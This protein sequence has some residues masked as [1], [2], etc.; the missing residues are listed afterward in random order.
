MTRAHVEGLIPPVRVATG[1]RARIRSCRRILLRMRVVARAALSTVGILCLAEIGEN[2]PHLVAAET[3]WRA[4]YEGAACGIA[5]CE[6]GYCGGELVADCAMPRGLSCHLGNGDAR[7]LRIMATALTAG[8]LHGLELM[9]LGAM[10]L[11]AFHV[12]EHGRVGLEMHA[13]SRG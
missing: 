9:E 1:R 3:L 5:R 10:A 12:L 11:Y 4:G 2:L 13:V 8:L 6:G 7:F